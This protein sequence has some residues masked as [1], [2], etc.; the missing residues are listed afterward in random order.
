M[1]LPT[2]LDN[3]IFEELGAQ[4]CPSYA[5]MTNI[6]DDRDATLKYLGTYFPR[7]YAEAYSIFSDYFGNHFSEWQ[8]REEISIFDFGCGTGG[9][10]V[11]LLTV[12]NNKFNNLK[13]VKIVALDGNQNALLRYEKIM[14]IMQETIQFHCQIEN[15]PAA[16]YI[17]DFYDL[18][19]LDAVMDENFDIVMSFKAICEFV[20]EQ[21]FEQK[22]PYEHIVN[23]MLPKLKS[24]GIILIEDITTKNC[25][26]DEWLP[27]MMDRGLNKTTCKEI[28]RNEGYNQMYL[29]THSHKSNDKSKVAWRMIK[30]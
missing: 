18:N 2:W 1:T 8:N 9:E 25:I 17:D 3:L 11:G 20:T 24:E 27:V 5:D 7:S 29:I 21:Q 10:I 30:R 28:E 14:K 15:H 22:N 12:L 26:S 6:H 16:I 4:Y 13:K 23:F 19:I